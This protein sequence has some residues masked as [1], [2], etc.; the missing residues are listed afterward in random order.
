VADT[1]Q[2]DLS[3]YIQTNIMSMTDGHIFF[4]LEL[5]VSGKRPAVNPFLSVTRVGKQVQQAVRRDI[6]REINSFFTYAQRLR[7]FAHFEQEATEAV[8]SV[9]E[10]ETRISE[11]F[12][13]ERSLIIPSSFQVMVFGLIWQNKWKDQTKE[14]MN[15][16]ILELLNKYEKDGQFR[17]MVDGTVNNSTNLNELLNGIIKTGLVNKMPSFNVSNN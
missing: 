11:F 15:K 4:D 2:G 5:F 7:S 13:Q 10:M 3:G 12:T 6:N 17:N 1:A 9:L 14:E 16:E 8:R